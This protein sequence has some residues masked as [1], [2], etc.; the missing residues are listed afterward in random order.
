MAYKC[1]CGNADE[2]FVAF[3][4]AVDVVDGKGEFVEIK[5]RNVAYYICRECEREIS[6]REFTPLAAA[7]ALAS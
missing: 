3:D 6:Y 4:V 5:E 1:K 2:F 7:S